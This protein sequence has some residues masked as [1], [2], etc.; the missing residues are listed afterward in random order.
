MPGE[1]EDSR[2]LA[3]EVLIATPAVRNLIRERRI[4]QIDNAIVT[5]AKFGMKTMD[6]SIYELLLA[7]KISYE[8]ALAHAYNVAQLKSLIKGKSTALGV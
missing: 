3:T 4:H 8:D 6:S 1:D 2:V 5:G 7:G